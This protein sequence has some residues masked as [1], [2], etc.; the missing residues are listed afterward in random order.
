MDKRAEELIGRVV[1]GCAT[2]AEERELHEM[3][4]KDPAVRSEL[5]QQRQAVQSMR[6]VGLRELQ[7]DV[8]DQF[9]RGVY[10]RIESRA[11]W[12][13]VVIGTAAIVLFTLYELCTDPKIATVYRVGLV[14]VI[15]GF[16]LLLSGAWRC[17]VR[18]ARGDM[19]KEVI[20]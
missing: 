4:N 19:Y 13:L 5:E 18:V 10:N 12:I 11:G 8:A 3:S 9:A 16:A 15:V 14:A 2:E 7:D 17:R 6:S 20:R 1:D